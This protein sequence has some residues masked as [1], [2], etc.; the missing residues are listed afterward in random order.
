MLNPELAGGALFDLGPYAAL[1]P[2]LFLFQHPDNERS[3]PE[4]IKVSA[5]LQPRLPFVAHRCLLLLYQASV[6]FD[7]RT[8]V[9]ASTTA[10]MTYKR[11]GAQATVSVS[12]DTPTAPNSIVVTGSKGTLSAVPRLALKRF[13]TADMLPLVSGAA[14][15]GASPYPSSFTVCL[16]D[17][18]D[19]PKTYSHPITSDHGRGMAWQ[20][21]AVARCLRDGKV[22]E[23]KMRWDESILQHDVF[24]KIVCSGGLTDEIVKLT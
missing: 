8:G 18:P 23:E 1:W 17:K 14:L 7:E 21:D 10:V 20:A 22:E 4:D 24:D 6:R 3:P 2:T 11:L 15:H 12:L 5:Y 9:D 16:F 13:R 19:D